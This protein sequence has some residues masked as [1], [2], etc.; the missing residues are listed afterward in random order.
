M[1]ERDP[2]IPPLVI[3]MDAQFQ[4][5]KKMIEDANT[6]PHWKTNEIVYIDCPK[7]EDTETNVSFA[8]H[9]VSK[10]GGDFGMHRTKLRTPENSAPQYLINFINR[11]QE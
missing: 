6:E 4:R 11:S 9:G 2:L 10:H 5:I 3:D 1:C 8:A 7:E